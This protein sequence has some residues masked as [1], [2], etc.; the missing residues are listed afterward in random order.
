MRCR[1]LL[2][3]LFALFASVS[4]GTVHGYASCP[5]ANL[6]VTITSSPSALIDTDNAQ[7]P[8]VATLTARVS[9]TGSAPIQNLTV[10]IGDGTTP[11]SFPHTGTRNLELLG[12]ASDAR[13]SSGVLLPGATQTLYWFVRYPAMEN[14]AYSYTVWATADGG[15]GDSQIA[16][17][18]VRRA[19]AS[20]AS[21]VRPV[22]GSVTIV[23]RTTITPG[24]LVTV[25]VTGFDLG[26]VGP[27]PQAVEDAWLQ[28]VSN[29][30][31]DP[32]C[33]RLVSSEVR[34]KSLKSEPYRDQLYFSGIG[35]HNPPPNYSYNADDYVRYTFIGLRR[36]TTQLQPY[37]QTAFGNGHQYNS[38]IGAIALAIQVDD[39][40]GGLALDSL[41][42]PTIGGAD[43]TL[44][45]TIAYGNTSGAPLGT[46]SAPLIITARI[47]QK[48]AAYIPNSATCST[49]CLKLWSTDE[50]ETFS[51]S[52]PTTAARVNVIRWVILDPVPAGQN[53]AGTVGF[54][55]KSLVNG[56]LCSTAQGAIHENIVISSDTSCVNSSTD[57]QIALGSSS[58]VRPGGALR[59]AIT[60][61][62]LG[63]SIAEDVIVTVNLPVEVQFVQSSPPPQSTSGQVLTYRLGSLSPNDG[64]SLALQVAVSP[65]L[66]E[67]ANLIS[68]ARIATATT[69]T[70]TANNSASST[71]IVGS[72][73]PQLTA[74]ARVRT[75]EDAPP[76]GPGPGDILEYSVTIKN[77][78]AVAATNV[79]FTATPDPHTQ[80]LIGSA[81]ASEGQIL[82]GNA[83]GDRQIRVLLAQFAP[84]ASETIEFRVRISDHP[85]SVRR[86]R[87][88]GILSCNELP[89]ILTDDPQTPI[90]ND[91]TDLSLG[92][93]PLLKAWKSFS[94]FNDLDGNGLPSPGDILK[95]TVRVENLGAESADSVVL[96]E[97]F[98]PHLTLVV[99]SV[100]T[101][102]GDVLSGNEV[103]ERFVRIN[104]GTVAPK[105]QITITYRA[106]INPDIPNGLAFVG[107]QALLNAAHIPSRPSD[108]PTTLA[109]DDPTLTPVWNSPQ[110]Y[111]GQRAYLKVDANGDGLPS[112]GDTLGY[113]VTLINRGNVDAQNAFFSS[114]PDFHT[115]LIVGS[116]RASQGSV[117]T[118]NASGET[119]IG[120][121]LDPIP[122]N[123]QA[124]ISFDLL[125]KDSL[126]SAIIG[127]VN[128]SLVNVPGAG[129]FSSDDPSTP[130]LHD[131]TVTSINNRP[132]LY[133]TK[134]IYAA[135]DDDRNGMVSAGELLEYVLTVIN[136]GTQEASG[137]QLS[138]ALGND[139][140]ILEASVRTDHG[141]IASGALPNSRELLVNLG[142][143]AAHGGRAH[144]SFQVRLQNPLSDRTLTNQAFIWGT[145]LSEQPS[146]DPRTPTLGDATVLTAGEFF[147]LCGD[148]DSDG[149]VDLEDARMV[150]Q[151]A[152]G[153]LQLTE[154][155]RAAAD[156]APPFGVIDARDATAIAEI[157][158]GYRLRCPIESRTATTDLQTLERAVIPLSVE[159]FVGESF[160]HA[161]RFQAEGRGIQEISVKV[162]NLSGQQV[163]DSDWRLGSELEW[164]GL[165][166][167]GRR[168]AN[169]VYLYLI[170]V[171]GA[172]GTLAQSRLQKLV[173]LR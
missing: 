89:D 157:A 26:A 159:R 163:F 164:R 55:L 120:I 16:A 126:P 6:I 81:S 43:T 35:S 102:Q 46:P 39:R 60:Y 15:C 73:A 109:E 93:G 38:D 143:L 90:P 24:E 97:G 74:T 123:G 64:G 108:D 133:F 82:S 166:R 131:P 84:D 111:I 62:N 168:V 11:G 167:D 149:D 66:S 77:T 138:D 21:R 88:Q 70:E 29:P 17:L 171:R 65:T 48:S 104:L 23:P 54:Q 95:Y 129:S 1:L 22:N 47:P 87:L 71:T 172:D 161:V 2:L 134:S 101:T 124:Q 5:Q 127:L 83:D 58:T 4:L 56:E 41:V 128:Q 150:G 170:S 44:A 59:Y 155:Q 98:E 76:L 94:L 139:M 9:N 147:I 7:S 51:A 50:G 10:F 116:V 130:A 63:P 86:I 49:N 19:T 137:L 173:I 37:Q 96:T 165:T 79:L 135:S 33:L 67:G 141:L 14:T 27:G 105:S 45:Y 42:S 125:I 119:T 52:E 68:T 158:Q 146:D 31:F 103:G 114:T 34:L 78:G 20:N 122:R 152:I 121:A 28:P 36:C 72:R 69:E 156:V 118:G 12:P 18:H 160:R 53:P 75:L 136:M 8:R 112:P 154:R 106:G 110:I 153:A 92:S 145:N 117:T 132:F 140:R 25:T 100:T 99:G 61:R 144:V 32:S 151:A 91:P 30:N 57:L 148:V 115:Q 113:S 162:F 3:S 169:G 142:A 40:T 13:R 85:S 80:L 107:G